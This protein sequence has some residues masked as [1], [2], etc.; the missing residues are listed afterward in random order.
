MNKVTIQEASRRLNVSQR[1]IREYIRRGSLKAERDPRIGDGPLAGGAAR[2]RLGG[3]LQGV[4]QPNVGGQTPWWWAFGAKTGKVH[5][6]LQVGI[7]EIMPDFLCGLR[8]ENL[9]PADGHAPDQR[10]PNC[11]RAAIEQELPMGTRGKAAPLSKA[12]RPG[13]STI[14][15][16]LGGENPY[17]PGNVHHPRRPLLP[18]S[19]NQTGG[20]C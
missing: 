6:L 1:D 9:Y 2:R 5:Y 11:L 12:G 14:T 20:I 19:R 16:Y 15:A 10:C 4:P 8:G 7:E 13:G 3:R 18:D 17:E